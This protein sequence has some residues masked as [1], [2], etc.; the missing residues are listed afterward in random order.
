MHTFGNIHNVQSV[1]VVYVL[2]RYA[3]C[4]HHT[5]IHQMSAV[6]VTVGRQKHVAFTG[7]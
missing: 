3:Q 5:Q 6:V 4:P 7:T 1:E 2:L